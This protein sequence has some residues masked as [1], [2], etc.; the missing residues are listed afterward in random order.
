MSDV[1]AREVITGEN[2]FE[3][4]KGAFTEQFVAQELN[5]ADFS[6]YY[7]S[8]ENSTLEIDFIVQKEDIYPIEVKAEENLKSK[9][10]RTVYENNESLRP[11]RFSMAGYR[12]QDWMFN[13]PLYL[14]REWMLSR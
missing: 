12:Q 1:T 5:S 14:A 10:L 3:E 13:I 2:Y 11:C 8:K 7:Y 9:S 4:Y 6:L